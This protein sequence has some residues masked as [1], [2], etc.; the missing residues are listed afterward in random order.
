M[1]TVCYV[2][3]DQWQSISVSN[4]YFRD[5]HFPLCQSLTFPDIQIYTI[6]CDISH[7]RIMRYVIDST[8]DST[9][10]FFFYVRSLKCI[11]NATLL[12]V[13]HY[14]STKRFKKKTN[15]TDYTTCFDFISSSGE[16]NKHHKY[17]F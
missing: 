11:R 12:H 10:W 1:N 6:L 8:I 13:L 5:M 3:S 9:I 17:M 4:K 14:S 15:S 2:S 7:T 16:K